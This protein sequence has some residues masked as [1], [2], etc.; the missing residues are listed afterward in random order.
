MTFNSHFS[1]FILDQVREQAGRAWADHKNPD[2]CP[3]RTLLLFEAK[4]TEYQRRPEGDFMLT[5][6]Q[7][8]EKSPDAGHPWYL[9]QPMGKNTIGMLVEMLYLL[10]SFIE[11]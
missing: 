5:I 6:S 7:K 11:I 4:K 9:N 10:T 3:V 1:F 2:T 8:A